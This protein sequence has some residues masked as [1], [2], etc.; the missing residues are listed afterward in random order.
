MSQVEMHASRRRLDTGPLNI[1]NSGNLSD[2]VSVVIH[3]RYQLYSPPKALDYSVNIF[4]PT[5]YSVA[6]KTVH[7]E[8]C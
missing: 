3:L 5:N 6:E 7:R 2:C 1:L 4:I 8:Q